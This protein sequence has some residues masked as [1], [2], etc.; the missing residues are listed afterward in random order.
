VYLSVYSLALPRAYAA[1]LTQS[2]ATA[3]GLVTG[4]WPPRCLGGSGRLSGCS[5]GSTGRSAGVDRG[6]VRGADR[7]VLVVDT[8]GDRT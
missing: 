8:G 5:T 7:G 6:A 2:L 3:G 4:L 1:L